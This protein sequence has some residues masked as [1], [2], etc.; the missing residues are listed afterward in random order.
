MGLELSWDIEGTKELS[1]VL[2]NV[3]T[4]TKDLTRPFT[5]ASNNLR[6]TFETEVFSSQGAV[7]AAKWK[8]LSP[9][10]V[11]Q[12]ARLGYTTEPMI[13]TGAMR[14]SFRTIVASD[15][16]TIYNVAPYFKYHQ[17]KLPRTKL[18]R[19]VMMRLADT[20]KQ[21]IVRVFQEHIRDIMK[22]V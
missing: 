17:S 19:R 4:R 8:R 1:R 15:R 9:Y 16:A 18:P 10:T 5:T 6:K 11:S 21:M 20:Q 12:K 3:R 14:G 22:N 2:L 13:R 7:I